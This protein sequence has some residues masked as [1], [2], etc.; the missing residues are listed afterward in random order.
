MCV[1]G[2]WNNA[3]VLFPSGVA[4]PTLLGDNKETRCKRDH[5][6]TLAQSAGAVAFEECVCGDLD[7][8]RRYV[9]IHTTTHTWS[10]LLGRMSC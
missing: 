1:Q 6:G 2:G 8:G 4:C 3:P 10:E 7:E 5:N 9:R